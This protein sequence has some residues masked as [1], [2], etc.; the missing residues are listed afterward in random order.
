VL[1]KAIELGTAL[2]S[3]G[4]AVE[5]QVSAALPVALPVGGAIIAIGVGWGLFKRFV[6]G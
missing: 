2:A 6:R 3:A 4:T 5:T 1:T